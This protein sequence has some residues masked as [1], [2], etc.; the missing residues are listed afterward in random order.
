MFN[1]NKLSVNRK[2]F[3]FLEHTELKCRVV[4]RIYTFNPIFLHAPL[5]ALFFILFAFYRRSCSYHDLYI[6]FVGHL[7]NYIFLKQIINHLIFTVL[8]K[9]CF[10]NLCQRK[11]M[12]LICVWLH[13]RLRS[14]NPTS[15]C[16][17]WVWTFENV[18]TRRK[19]VCDRI[20][21]DN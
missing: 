18:L 1:F 19:C 5:V 10:A 13:L 16:S 15:K 7:K 6:I 8:F 2:S 17:Y 21:Y 12:Q 11:L 9:I 14:T 4:W 20:L 3:N